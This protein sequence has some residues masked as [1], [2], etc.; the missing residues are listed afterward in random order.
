MG[1]PRVALEAGV[2]RAVATGGAGRAGVA[3]VGARGPHSAAR[4]LFGGK[5]ARGCYFRLRRHTCGGGASA[6]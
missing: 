6:Q 2:V 1:R 5:E 4:A 3:S